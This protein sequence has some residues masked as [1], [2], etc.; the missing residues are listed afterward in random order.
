MGSGN[1]RPGSTENRPSVARRILDWLPAALSVLMIILEST[2]TMS[3]ANTS[4]FLYPLW[5]RLFGPL[6]TEK[7]E[8]IHHYIRKTGHFMGYG[9]VSLTF[10]YSWRQTLHHMAV[11]HWTLWRRASVLAVVCT[12]VIASLDEYHQSFLPSRTSSVFDVG[13]DL[14]GAIV[15]QSLLLLVISR[16]SR[17]PGLE[18]A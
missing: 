15:F 9:V 1:T 14:C 7:W 13:I 5:V 8:L 2:A 6:S 4:H 17:R 10:F 3:A 16:F 12:L 11:R 18:P